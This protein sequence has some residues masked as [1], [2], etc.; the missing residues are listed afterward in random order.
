MS[1]TTFG[2]IIETAVGLSCGMVEGETG[3]KEPELFASHYIAKQEL[4]EAVEEGMD[5]DGWRVEPITVN[6]DFVTLVNSGVAFNWK[7]GV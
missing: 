6:G 3:A 5:V 7:V 4:L 2:I 1:Q